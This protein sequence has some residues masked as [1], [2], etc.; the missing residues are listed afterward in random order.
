VSRCPIPGFL[1]FFYDSKTG[2]N[3]GKNASE[4]YTLLKIE[5]LGFFIGGCCQFFYDSKL[6]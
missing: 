3:F 5:R 1:G 2:A 4:K 6:G